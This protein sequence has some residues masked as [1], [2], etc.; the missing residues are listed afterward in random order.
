MKIDEKYLE[1]LTD[2]Q[3]KKVEAA[4]SADELVALAE[5]FGLNL[6]EEQLD[7]ITGGEFYL[8]KDL[9]H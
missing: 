4:K 8:F 6:T 2:E 7:S 1:G 3:K 5:E 9:P